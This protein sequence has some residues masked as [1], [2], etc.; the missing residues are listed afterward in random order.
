MLPLDGCLGAEGPPYE[1]GSGSFCSC[2]IFNSEES[3]QAFGE[4][5]LA[6]QAGCLPGGGGADRGP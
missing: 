4:G 6:H 2:Y 3:H 5:K 1:R